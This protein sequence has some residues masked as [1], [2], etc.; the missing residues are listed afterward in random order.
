[1]KV[2][3]SWSGSRS[4]QAAEALRD[5]L[6]TVIQA[7]E[8]WIS[9]HS[10]DKGARGVEEIGGALAEH[11]VGILCI[12]RDNVREPW[13]LFEAGAIAKNRERCWTF[14]LDLKPGDVEP[15][16]S[17]FQHTVASDKADVHKLV[18]S[19]NRQLEASK[20]KPLDDRRLDAAFE[21]LWPELERELARV[22]KAGNSTRAVRGDRE[23]L[24]EILE[25]VRQLGRPSPAESV[26][27]SG[28]VAEW[29]WAAKHR[30]ANHATSRFGAN[31]VGSKADVREK[32]DN[33]P[34]LIKSLLKAV[35]YTSHDNAS[36]TYVTVETVQPMQLQW[37]RDLFDNLGLR[38]VRRVSVEERAQAE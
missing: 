24:E 10:I 6:P 13:L 14:L 31:V 34:E 23:L 22:P 37:F 1:M 16:L 17:Q 18:R 2:F 12:T 29:L 21:R 20:E 25:L 3:M 35:V 9:T 5:W 28:A 4:R 7:V 33:A 15:P 8:P 30:D 11:Q 26:T 27:G 36:Y 19:I 38:R 32:F